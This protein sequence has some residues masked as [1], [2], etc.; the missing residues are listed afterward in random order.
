ML[1]KSSGCLWDL[2]LAGWEHSHAA[3]LCKISVVLGRL[4]PIGVCCSFIKAWSTGTVEDL[5]L[6]RALS[7]VDTLFN[8]TFGLR[9]V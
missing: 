2:D 4:G 7:S 1:L 3:F 6:L 5:A 9:V 8:E